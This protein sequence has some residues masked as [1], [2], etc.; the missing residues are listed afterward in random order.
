VFFPL[1]TLASRRGF[2]AVVGNPPWEAIRRWDDQ[3]FAAF[4]FEA[5]VGATKREKKEVQERLLSVPAIRQAYE[6]YVESFQE[7]DR[8]YDSTFTVHKATV[9]GQ[10]A[11]RGTY[12]A[13]MLFA[14]RGHH[15]LRSAGQ[16]GWV[17]PSA[18]HANEGATGVRRL[19]LE[20]MALGCCYSF[21]NRRKLFEIHRSFKFALVVA[22]RGGPTSEFPCAFYLHDDEWLFGD[23]AGREPLRYTLDF[24]Q[25]TG[26]EYLSL[27]ELRSEMDLQVAAACFSSGTPFGVF[28][29]RLRIRL[30]QE[31]N[32]TYDAGRFTPT[33][34]V[35]R[36]AEDPRNPEIGMR[37]LERGYL[38]L[39]EGKTFHQYD[40]RWDERPRY[41]V[42]LDQLHDRPDWLVGV[43]FY[44]LAFRDIA[45]STNERTAIFACLP[46]GCTFGNKAPCVR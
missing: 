33:A 13:F 43:P 32:M 25:R 9:G 30:G 7:S 6:A 3:F 46:P 35:L 39:H 22:A 23:R 26:G 20:Q 11:G 24:V 5:L 1:G 36:G 19:Y 28:C 16:L 45:S 15:L 34:E 2:D 21:E 27:L 18:F 31:L 12:D 4:D 42:H 10:L 29:E 38:V 41:T 40:D 17:L 8:I 14:E 44:R 37:L